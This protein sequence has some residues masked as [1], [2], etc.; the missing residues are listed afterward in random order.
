MSAA[1][2][3]MGSKLRAAN[4]FLMSKSRNLLPSFTG[5]ATKARRIG[6]ISMSLAEAGHTTRRG[7]TFNPAQVRAI[8][9]RAKQSG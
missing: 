3:P 6:Q 9:E 1:S 7:T 2:R 5:C 8:V 4:W